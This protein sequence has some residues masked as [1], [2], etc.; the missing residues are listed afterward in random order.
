MGR[1]I[2]EGLSEEVRVKLRHETR[3]QIKCQSTKKFL[4]ERVIEHRK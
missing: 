2:R 1:E 3:S 4:L